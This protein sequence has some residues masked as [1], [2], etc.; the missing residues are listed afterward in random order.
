MNKLIK[1]P[2]TVLAI[3]CLFGP[4]S[5]A[6]A[7]VSVNLGAA[8]AFAVLAGST[9]TNTGTTVINGDLGLSPGT[10]V[11]GFPPGVLNGTLHVSDANAAQAQ[12]S[13]SNA[14]SAASQP[15]DST[16]PSELGGTTRI[17]GVYDSGNGTFGI[18]GTLTLDGQ[19]DPNAVFIFKTATTLI[20][21][22]SS[23]VVLINGAQACNVFW[24]VGSSATLGASSSFKGTILAAVSATLTTSATVEG[25]VLTQGG[26]VTLDTSVVNRPVCVAPAP[27]VVAV[28]ATTTA[29]TSAPVIIPTQTATTTIIFTP[30]AP[31]VP[32]T[33]VVTPSFPDTGTAPASTE[34]S[35]WASLVGFGIFASLLALYLLRIKRTVPAKR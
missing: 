15:T 9:V 28:A 31:I 29:T 25:R 30:T 8:G 3:V 1:V 34:G 32:T 7:A 10:S 22:G 13:L 5:P 24:Q 20:T 27:V 11:T 21:A 12:I 18:T 17:A 35:K 14:F 19:G 23:N 6:L 16:I 2:V 26:A 33:I 4:A